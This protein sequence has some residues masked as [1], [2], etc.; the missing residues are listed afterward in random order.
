MPVAAP[1]HPHARRGAHRPHRPHRRRRVDRLRGRPVGDDAGARAARTAGLHCTGP[2]A[3]RTGPCAFSAGR[4]RRV[5]PGAGAAGPVAR[6]RAPRRG[7]ARTVGRPLAADVCGACPRQ[8]GR[9][10]LPARLAAHAACV[11]CRRRN[12]QAP[13]ADARGP[14][15]ARAA[16]HTHALG[17]RRV[18]LGRGGVARPVP[19]TRHRRTAR[20]ARRSA[21]DQL[22]ASRRADG[23]R[24]VGGGACVRTGSG[25]HRV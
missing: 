3:R 9:G 19:A 7:A 11:V 13:R 15:Q 21:A 22:P 1:V 4:A 10:R 14:T 25:L 5:R 8:R 12:A 2:R 17:R 20:A 24:Q 6:G 18:R 23:Q 16:A